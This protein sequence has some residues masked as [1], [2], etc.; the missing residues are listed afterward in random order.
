MVNAASEASRNAQNAR[1]ALTSEVL[2]AV[3]S[4]TTLK[5]D[6]PLLQRPKIGSVQLKM[7]LASETVT[8]LGSLDNADG[9][10]ISVGVGD[11]Q[12]WVRAAQVT[13]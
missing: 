7:L 12:G 9:Q 11:T 6:T 5:T 13:P 8:L 10:W 3:A 2:E 4:T 1:P